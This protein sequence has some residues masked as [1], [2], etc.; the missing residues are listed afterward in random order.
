MSKSID[1]MCPVPCSCCGEWYD[2]DSLV[3]Y[4]D[5]GDRLICTDCRDGLEAGKTDCESCG[6]RHQRSDMRQLFGKWYCLTCRPYKLPGKGSPD[7]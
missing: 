2:L 6:D 7:A 5:T 4:E 3:T 1:D